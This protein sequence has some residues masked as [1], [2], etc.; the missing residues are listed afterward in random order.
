MSFYQ[1]SFVINHEC[2][3]LLSMPRGMVGGTKAGGMAYLAAEGF[4]TMAGRTARRVIERVRA[5]MV[6]VWM[7]GGVGE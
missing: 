3:G 6:C 4:A 7:M 5:F 2:V 1:V